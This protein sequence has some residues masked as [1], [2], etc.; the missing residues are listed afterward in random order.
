MGH[1]DH[2]DDN[3]LVNPPAGVQGV[4]VDV[5]LVVCLVPRPP[6]VQLGPHLLHWPAR[7]LMD[8]IVIVL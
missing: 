4:P 2:N 6:T 7:A 1:D 8:I 3:H 5:G